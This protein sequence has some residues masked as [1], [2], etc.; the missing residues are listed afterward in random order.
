MVTPVV[1][2][3]KAAVHAACALAWALEPP[4]VM[5]PETEVSTAGALDDGVVELLDEHAESAIADASRTAPAVAT[6]L[7][8]TVFPFGGDDSAQRYRGHAAREPVLARLGRYGRAVSERPPNGER[9]VNA[10]PTI[11]AGS[12]YSAAGP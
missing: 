3:V 1:W 11:G 4:A 2:A 8:F 9:Q 7:N 6:F 10:A 12:C 5:V